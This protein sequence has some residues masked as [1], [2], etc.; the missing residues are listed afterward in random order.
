MITCKICNKECNVLSRHLFNS[1]KER[2]M[3]VI[4]DVEPTLYDRSG[5]ETWNC[6][7]RVFQ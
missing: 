1:H 6:G 2:G 5:Y 7:F 3:K 4:K